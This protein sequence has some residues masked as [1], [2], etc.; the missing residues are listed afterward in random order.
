MKSA[1]ETLEHA[2]HGLN[3]ELRTWSDPR[4]FSQRIINECKQELKEHKEAL[5]ILKKND[6]PL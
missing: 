5:K 3:L 1:I 4:N 2:I 6:H